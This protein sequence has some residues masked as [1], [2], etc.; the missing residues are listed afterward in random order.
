[1]L[2]YSGANLAT[3]IDGSA[4][5]G[6]WF[7]A[8]NLSQNSRFL[9]NDGVGDSFVEDRYTLLNLGLNVKAQDLFRASLNSKTNGYLKGRGLINIEE[10]GYTL[11]TPNRSRYQVDELAL[12]FQKVVPQLD[13]WLGRQTL[14]EVSGVSF[15]GLRA[16]YHLGTTFDLAVY[17]GLGTDPRTLTG[18]IGPS[19][20]SYPFTGKFQSVGIYTSHRGQKIRTDLAF[21]ADLFKAKLDRGYIFSQ[22]IYDAT[23][24]WT[25]SALINYGVLED[26]GIKSIQANAISRPTSRV[27]NTLSFSRYGALVYKESGASVIPVPNQIDEDLVGEEK[28]NTTSYNSIRDHLM[29][30]V[31]DRNYVFGAFQFS[32]RTFDDQNQMKYTAGYRDPDLL[33]STFDL[34][35]QTDLIDN[36]RGFN[37]VFDALL[38]KEFS[39]GAL[40]IEAG[41]SFYGN[42]R[43]D[44]LDNEPTPNPRQTEKEYT[45]RSNLYYVTTQK[46]S[47]LLN[48]AL[49]N[50]I[51]ATN[52]D[53]KVRSHEVYL[54][55]N[56]RF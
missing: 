29:L 25:F 42:E 33:G 20:K 9:A 34:R 2:L 21:H 39:S 56:I 41:G 18:Y 4:D 31:F 52:Q 8:N 3:E 43:D 55:T 45:L 7:V 53:Q 10:K 50:E 23:S 54:A 28:V 40:R 12:E 48:Y 26:I 49:H 11:G 38:G 14:Y 6:F 46:V 51:D 5:L 32:R 36:Y 17:G 16:L 24:K 19:Y 30:R 47:W 35:L 37:S 44:L 27:T 22:A 15:D 1:M 13:L